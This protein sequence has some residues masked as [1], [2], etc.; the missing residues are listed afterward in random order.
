MNNANKVLCLNCKPDSQLI[1][2]L[3]FKTNIS[4]KAYGK[5]EL[6]QTYKCNEVCSPLSPS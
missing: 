5:Y 6:T 4:T 2:T 3:N 1:A